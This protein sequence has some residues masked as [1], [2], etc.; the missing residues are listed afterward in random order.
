MRKFQRACLLGAVTAAAILPLR[1]G[2]AHGAG[3]R[4]GRLGF[5]FTDFSYLLGDLSP[6]ACPDGL[7][8]SASEIYLAQARITAAER[9]RL[10]RPENL[11]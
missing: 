6:A 4:E 10:S 3:L 2:S 8:R 7:A 5:V 11:R 1:P 9:A